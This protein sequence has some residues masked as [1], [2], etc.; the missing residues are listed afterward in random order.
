MRDETGAVVFVLFSFFSGKSFAIFLFYDLMNDDDNNNNNNNHTGN[1]LTMAEE[2]GGGNFA[3]EGWE[4]TKMRGK[5]T[6]G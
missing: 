6:P 1:D 4:K 2:D 5:E 3:Y